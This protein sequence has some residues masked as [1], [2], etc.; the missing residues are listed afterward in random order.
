VHSPLLQCARPM[1]VCHRLLAMSLLATRRRQADGGS[2]LYR[3]MSC[4]SERPRTPLPERPFL[5]SA[6]FWSHG[7]GRDGGE[8][9]AG[10]L[11]AP[12]RRLFRGGA[13]APLLPRNETRV[14]RP[15]R[16]GRSPVAPP[17]L[18]EM[19]P[20]GALRR[21]A[22]H[23]RVLRVSTGV[24]ASLFR[25]CAG[26]RRRVTPQGRNGNSLET[27]REAGRDD[28]STSAPSPFSRRPLLDLASSSVAALVFRCGVRHRDCCQRHGYPASI[29]RPRYDSSA[30]GRD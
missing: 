14:R 2:V 26:R 6:R 11:R 30:S 20:G 10:G 13:R 5:E 4:I 21:A 12:P 3:R 27:E 1:A 24:T 28:A 25:I 17:N 15:V 23:Q 19:T 22:T 29:R 7:R 8:E 9:N 18:A 16:A